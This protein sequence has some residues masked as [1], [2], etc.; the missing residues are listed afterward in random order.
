MK[1]ILS[2]LFLSFHAISK[3][4]PADHTSPDQNKLEFVHAVYFWLHDHVTEDQ[5]KE[6]IKLLKGFRKIKSVSRVYVGVPARTP[7]T[8]VDNTYDIALIVI[9][10]D[11]AGH[12]HYQADSI[13]KDAIRTFDGWVRDMRIYD[14]VGDLQQAY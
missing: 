11:K 3:A 9:L 12:D 2:V 14:S 13:H 5:K 10:R 1:V 7:R 8:V 4:A 6:F